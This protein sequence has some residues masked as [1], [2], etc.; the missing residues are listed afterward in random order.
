MIKFTLLLFSFLFSM[1]AHAIN[2]IEVEAAKSREVSTT[3]MLEGVVEAE[4]RTTISSQ[5]SGI[6]REIRFDVNDYVRKDEIVVVIDDKQQKSS[7]RQAEAVEKEAR[8][9]LQEA[10][11]EYTRVEKVYRKKVV[12]KSDF[13]RV[14]AGLAAAKARVESSQAATAPAETHPTGTP[15]P[16][17]PAL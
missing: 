7:L 11:S 15:S 3:Y 12:S 16:V 2:G 6:V 8:V 10:Q 14:K 13:D 4:L 1:T 5:T 9:R 17:I